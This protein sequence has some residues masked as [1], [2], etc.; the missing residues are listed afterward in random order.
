MDENIAAARPRSGIPGTQSAPAPTLGLSPLSRRR[1]LLLAAPL[2]VL[3]PSARA[4]TPLT[5]TP[6]QM[7]GPYYPL[8]PDA[9]A[10]NDLTTVDGKGRARGKALAI[11]GRV[12]DA[13]GRP[14]AGVL[15]EIWQTNAHGR[16]H[17]PHD[18]SPPASE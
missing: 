13:G 7:L 11:V 8:R 5:A 15:V 14:Q 1:R 18:N 3:L 10:G 4:A 2:I 17:H 12:T 9:A 16:Y 6:S